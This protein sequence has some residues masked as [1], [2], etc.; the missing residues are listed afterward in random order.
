MSAET[1]VNMAKVAWDIIKDGA[2]SAELTNSTANAVPQVDDWQALTNATGP[3]WLQRR[4]AIEY[5]WPFDGYL[6]ADLIVRLNWDFG[7]RYRGGGAYIPNIWVEVPECFVG[8]PWDA[9]LQLTA[10]NPTN[11]SGPGEPPVARIP[12]T[13]R[14]TISSPAE[15][16]HVDWGFVLFGT[17][18]Y[19]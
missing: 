11:A 13:V 18:D 3:R 5:L 14:G 10:R 17:G 12:V 8:W 7:A 2:P 4:R 15:V 19:E 9:N 6:H 16:Y 1:V